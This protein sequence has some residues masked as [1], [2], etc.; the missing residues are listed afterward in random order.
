[1]SLNVMNWSY[2]KKYY[3]THPWKWFSELFTNLCEAYRRVK[4]GWAYQDCWNLDYWV[5]EILPPMLRHMADEGCAYPG[6]KPFETPEQWNDWLHST[7]DVLESLQEDNWYSQNEYEKDF[8]QLSR[9]RDEFNSNI[10]LTN[11]QDYE[12]LSKLYLMRTHELSDE[13]Q[14]LIE[15]TF[16]QL[17]KYFTLLWD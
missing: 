8:H 7:A 11:G 3:L 4:Y 1:M 6:N 12:T 17:A 9:W 5:L 13:R 15:N 16:L 10:T 2:T 14:K